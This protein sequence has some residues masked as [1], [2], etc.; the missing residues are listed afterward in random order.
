MLG[1]MLDRNYP[2]PVFWELAAEEGCDVILGCDAHAPEHLLREDT[3]RQLLAMIR[4]YGLNL[5]E[6]APLRNI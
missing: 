2:N 5:L 6:K 1:K 3:E 4:S